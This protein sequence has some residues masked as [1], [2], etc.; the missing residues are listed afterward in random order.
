MVSIE[1]VKDGLARYIDA[2][3]CPSMS[4]W[5][6]IIVATGAGIAISKLDTLHLP[7]GLTQDGEIDVDAIY[8]EAKKH[9]SGTMP[10]DLPMIGTVEISATDI[11]TMYNY[12]VKC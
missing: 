1:R 11:D 6:R 8:N 12:I 9:I 7:L 2:E 5:R 10:I 4:G 3:L